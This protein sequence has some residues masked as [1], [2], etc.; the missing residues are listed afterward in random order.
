MATFSKA[1]SMSLCSVI[2]GF[3]TISTAVSWAVVYLVA[4]PE[5]QE[6]L[7]Q[8]I[9]EYNYITFA[10]ITMFLGNESSVA[11]DTVISISIYTLSKGL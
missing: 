1:E 3:D 8:E 10:T 9:S 7:H 2:A 5:V 4:Y 11:P 6:K